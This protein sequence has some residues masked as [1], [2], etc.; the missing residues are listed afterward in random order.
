ML[1]KKRD[2][3][4]TAIKIVDVLKNDKISKREFEE[5]YQAICNEYDSKALFP[6]TKLSDSS[7]KIWV[8]GK[9]EEVS[10]IVVSTLQNISK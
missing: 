6:E 5:I 8:N 3:T 7:V 9:C 4:R 10:D 1:V 2:N